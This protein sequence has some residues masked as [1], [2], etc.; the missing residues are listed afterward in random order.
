VLL[1]AVSRL[2]TSFHLR[3]A[4]NF[5]SVAKPTCLEL[6]TDTVPSYFSPR[7]FCAIFCTCWCSSTSCIQIASSLTFF[8][9]VDLEWPFVN[10]LTVVSEIST[11][12][13]CSTTGSQ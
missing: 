5:A 1:V 8:E 7:C 10:G 4:L 12:K 3:A 9:V 13:F 6:A 11:A 2:L